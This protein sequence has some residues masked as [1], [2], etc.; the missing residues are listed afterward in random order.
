MTGSKAGSPDRANWNLPSPFESYPGEL[1][2]SEY[3][4]Y[5]KLIAELRMYELSW[6]LRSKPDWQRKASDPQILAKWRREALDQQESIGFDKRMTEKMI[7]YVLA[8]LTGY[9]KIADNERGIER[10]CFDA[11]WYSD[12]VI[13][14]DVTER[15]KI[16]VST[17]ENVPQTE[18]DWHPGSNGQVLDLVHPSLYCIVYGRTH[19]YLPAQPRVPDNLLPVVAP[20]FEELEADWAISE[21]FCWMPSDFYVGMD[22]SVKL[23]S[24]YINNLHPAQHQPLYRVIEEILSGFIPMFDRVL[25]DIDN[26]NLATTTSR[27]SA[28][29]IWGDEG[30]EGRPDYQEYLEETGDEEIMEEKEWYDSQKIFPEAKFTLASWRRPFRQF[31]CVEGRFNASSNSPIF[32]S[33]LNTLNMPAAVGTSRMANEH[34]VASGIYYYD[35]ENITESRLSFRVP[36]RRP[37]TMGI[38]TIFVCL[39]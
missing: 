22:G 34:I 37:N 31:R 25:G 1:W 29:C 30:R 26:Q 3:G 38:T 21:V 2:D 32:I 10:G 16:A 23:V 12:R 4:R 28:G 35:E 27:V 18:K 20:T 39:L 9:A 14:N 33:P 24:P 6:V 19:A 5:P 11:I 15:L 8:E 7:D 13:S 36:T 17:L